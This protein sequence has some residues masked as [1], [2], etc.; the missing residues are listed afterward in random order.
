MAA[1]SALI[2]LEPAAVNETMLF[3]V[4]ARTAEAIRPTRLLQRSL[5]LL[6]STVEPLELRQGKTFLELNRTARHERTNIYKPVYDLAAP[7]AEQ[8]E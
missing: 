7:R 1:E 2:T 6:L 4:A 8:A 3:A 5:T